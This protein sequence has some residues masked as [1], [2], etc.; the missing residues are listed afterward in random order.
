VYGKRHGKG[1]YTYHDGG[2]YEG[3]W[4]DDKV[5]NKAP[6]SPSARAGSGC[7]L[8]SVLPARL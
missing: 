7:S 2:K 3:E 6:L 5:R 1:A 8:L 4:V